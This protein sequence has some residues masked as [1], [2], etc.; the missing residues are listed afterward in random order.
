MWN[1]IGPGKFNIDDLRPALSHCTHLVYG[2]AGINTNTKE[3]FPLNPSLDTGAGYG[4]YKLVTQLKKSFPDVKF[5]LSIGGDADAYE[6]THKYLTVVSRIFKLI[7]SQI[8]KIKF[9][10]LILNFKLETIS[11]SLPLILFAI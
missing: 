8:V 3:A 6:E 4:H 9:L 2:F 11:F 10:V 7:F 1:L 5:I